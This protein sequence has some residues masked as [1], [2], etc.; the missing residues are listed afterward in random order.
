M[1]ENFNREKISVCKI[2]LPEEKYADLCIPPKEF[3]FDRFRL[4]E[5]DKEVF[6]VE[7]ALLLTKIHPIFIWS[8]K[9]YCVFG[10]RTLYIASSIIPNASIEVGVLPSNTEEC[11]VEKFILA[12]SWLAKLAYSTKR[13]EV[14]LFRS[15]QK[16]SNETITE[17]SPALDM[18]VV[19]FAK[20]L[21]V[22]M[23]TLYSSCET[24]K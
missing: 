3:L 5:D 4:G 14:N 17:L 20:V 21:G 24:K 8:A 23:P 9:N 6:S 15:R 7:A 16:M 10:I 12:D 2:R 18:S 22:S 11:E 13:P 19:K 1:L